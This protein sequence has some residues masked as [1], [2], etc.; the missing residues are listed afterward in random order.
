MHG[1][2]LTSDIGGNPPPPPLMKWP[3]GVTS[4]E[5][6]ETGSPAGLFLCEMV[7]VI[8]V[9]LLIRL[10][11][12]A[13]AVAGVVLYAHGD[14]SWWLFVALALAPDLA[15]VGYAAGPAV[16]AAAYNLTHNLVFPLA[17]GTTGVVWDSDW[18][19]AIALIWLVHIGVD[20][21][22]GYGLKYPTAFKDTHLQHV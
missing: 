12:I 18:A 21:A 3:F 16:G 17:L 4:I 5:R 2:P 8:P 10:E 1:D 6:L 19:V 11:G 14:H 15:F 9:W 13:I 22:I 7:A 20:R